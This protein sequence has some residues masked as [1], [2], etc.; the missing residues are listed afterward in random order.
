[1]ALGPDNGSR[2]RLIIVL[3]A[4]VLV[5]CAV[6]AGTLVKRS[7]EPVRSAASLCVQLDQAK[8]LDSALTSLDPTTLTPQVQALRTA[9]PVAPKEIATEISTLSQFIGSLLTDVDEAEVRDRRQALSDAL[10]RRKDEIDTVTDAGRAVQRWAT[11]N[12]GLDLGR[13]VSSVEP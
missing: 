11:D 9:V 1:M 7:G 5:I 10:A 8:N 13:S 2:R 4:G 12:C 3:A 6:V